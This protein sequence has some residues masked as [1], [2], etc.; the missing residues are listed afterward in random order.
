M[1]LLALR[2]SGFLGLKADTVLKH[3]ACSKIMRS[4]PTSAAGQDA[5]LAADEEVCKAIVKKFEELGD[6]DFSYAEI[7]KKAWEVGRGGLATK[8]TQS[9]LTLGV[10]T[11][12]SPDCLIACM[13]SFL[14]MSPEGQTKYHFYSR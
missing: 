4:K 8:V 7:A 10:V 11:D 5:E 9:L 13:C 14:I 1:H 3:W 2:I 12:I 6:T